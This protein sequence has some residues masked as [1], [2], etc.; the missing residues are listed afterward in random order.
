MLLRH[1]F[2]MKTKQL[3]TKK[4]NII[5]SSIFTYS[6][7]LLWTETAIKQIV[8]NFQ[9]IFYDKSLAVIHCFLEMM[10]LVENFKLSTQLGASLIEISSENYL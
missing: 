5:R 3:C 9:M 2:Q 8:R 7:T 1:N 10:A 4:F 6:C